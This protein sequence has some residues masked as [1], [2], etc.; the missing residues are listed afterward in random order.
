[1]NKNNKEAIL[2]KSSLDNSTGKNEQLIIRKGETN[3]SRS[4]VVKNPN[5]PSDLARTLDW[6]KRSMHASD[7]NLFDEHDPD[8]LIVRHMS[9]PH[10]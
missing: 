8:P 7:K 10:R 2:L 3:A 4:S 5:N 1:M 6:W 9:L